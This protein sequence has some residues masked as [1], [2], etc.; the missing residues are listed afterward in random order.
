MIKIVNV[1]RTRNIIKV[2]PWSFLFLIN[3]SGSFLSSSPLH[4]LSRPDGSSI[5]QIF[6]DC[7][8]LRHQAPCLAPRGTSRDEGLGAPGPGHSATLTGLRIPRRRAQT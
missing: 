6:T 4:S 1:G 5:R 2:T 7:F 8:L 3:R